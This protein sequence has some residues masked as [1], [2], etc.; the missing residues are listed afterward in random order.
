MYTVVA[1]L[2]SI[3]FVAIAIW[4]FV[5]AF[6]AGTGSSLA[7]P[8]VNGKPLFVPSRRATISVGVALLAFAV[9]VI[10]TAGIVSV[11]L[12]LRLLSWLSYALALGLVARAIG[13]FRYVGFFKRVRE[14][15]FAKADTFVYSPLCLLLALGVVLVAIHNDIHF[16][17]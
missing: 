17:R 6:S 16:T 1:A 4:H 2:V 3:A 10:A 9:L 5:M 12:P 15:K 13:E 8:S 7:I 14:S 11:G